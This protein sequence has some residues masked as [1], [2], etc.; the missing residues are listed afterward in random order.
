MFFLQQLEFHSIVQKY[1][2]RVRYSLRLSPRINRGKV[3]F[4]PGLPAVWLGDRAIT[5]RLR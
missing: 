3:F 5:G 2:A 1:E 4:T